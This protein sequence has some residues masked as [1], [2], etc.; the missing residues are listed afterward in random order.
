MRKSEFVIDLHDWPLYAGYNGNEIE[1]D[2]ALLYP[3]QNQRLG[4]ILNV[5]A[6]TSRKYKIDVLPTE[7]L[8]S[9]SPNSLGLES[10]PVRLSKDGRFKIM[11]FRD[12]EFFMKE[13][14]KFIEKNYARDMG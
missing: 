11:K 13:L 3:E 1:T 6:K 2:Y 4:D 5:Y 14:I 8:D 10:Y 12:A 9:L 7:L